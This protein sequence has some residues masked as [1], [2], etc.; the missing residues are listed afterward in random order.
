MVE[1]N[2][3]CLDPSIYGHSRACQDRRRFTKADSV[4][5]AERY[6]AALEEI[7]RISCDT[8]PSNAQ[9]LGGALGRVAGITLEALDGR[10]T[11][12]TGGV[13]RT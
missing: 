7:M 6:K 12:K 10:S 9:A 11:V 4:A 2:C 13:R 8:L 3:H 5:D 1:R